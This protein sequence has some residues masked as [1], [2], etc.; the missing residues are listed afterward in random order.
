MPWRQS[1]CPRASGRGEGQ[2]AP[3]VSSGQAPARYCLKPHSF[4]PM[5]Q[6]GRQEKGSGRIQSC[7]WRPGMESVGICGS[8]KSQG[9]G[10]RMR[11]PVRP[12]LPAGLSLHFHAA[13]ATFHQSW[14]GSRGGASVQEPFLELCERRLGRH[15]GAEAAH[16]VMGDEAG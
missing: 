7:D 15:A 8:Q 11:I 9:S 13:P 12:S 16:A 5:E 3:S 1:P 6:V 4:M 10:E 2:S 14:M